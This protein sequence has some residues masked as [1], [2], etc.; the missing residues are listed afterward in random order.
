[1][2]FTERS[3]LSDES[4]QRYIEPL[5]ARVD[6]LKS[7]LQE[8]AALKDIETEL[9]IYRHHLGEFGYQMFVLQKA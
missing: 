3:R 7:T 9:S 4:W 5:K 2:V 6:V 8:S 1:M